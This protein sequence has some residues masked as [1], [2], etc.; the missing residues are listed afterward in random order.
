MR[1][2]APPG[3]GGR[4]WR[5]AARGAGAV[6]V[7][8]VAFLL[9]GQLRT[10]A[11]LSERLEVASEQDLTRIFAGLNEEAAAL[12]SEITELQIQLRLLESSAERERLAREAASRELEQLEVLAGLV[13]AA[14]PGIVVRIDDPFGAVGFELLL[15]LVQELRNARAEAIAI[16]DVR[17]GATTYIEA[18]GTGGA[19]VVGG[20]EVR[21][22]YDVS[23]IG[24]PGT[25]EGGLK[26]PGGAADTLGALAG[27]EVTIER[28]GEVRVPALD[29][30]P[31]F[32]EARPARDE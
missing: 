22:P 21:A 25:L 18:A 31:S 23:A 24:D 5:R 29:R 11:P 4:R 10:E 30:P 32:D 6:T 27:V 16:D 7:A 3:R 8:V 1:S 14:G 26:I 9:V 12:R 2:E 20:D 28:Q 15:D 19:V 13:P 17:V